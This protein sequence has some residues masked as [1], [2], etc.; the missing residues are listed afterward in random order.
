MSLDQQIGALKS[1]RATWSFGL[2]LLAMIGSSVIV[3]LPQGDPEGA[4]LVVAAGWILLLLGFAYHIWDTTE[5]KIELLQQKEQTDNVTNAAMALLTKEAGGIDL[6]TEEFKAAAAPVSDVAQAAQNVM[7]ALI[8][9]YKDSHMAR[10]LMITGLVLM[11][12]GGVK[13]GWVDL[14]TLSME[15]SRTETMVEGGGTPTTAPEATPT[16]T[17][18]S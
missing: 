18:S 10:V 7:S 12:S 3:F 2:T 16:K 14:P 17:L 6:T 4:A 9:F 13:A 11:L 8:E 1:S 5:A 15:I